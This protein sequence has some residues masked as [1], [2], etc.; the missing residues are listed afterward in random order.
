M[1]AA[2]KVSGKKITGIK[3]LKKINRKKTNQKK[4][5]SLGKMRSSLRRFDKKDFFSTGLFSAKIQDFIFEKKLQGTFLLV[6]K[7]AYVQF[8]IFFYYLCITHIPLMLSSYFA[9]LL[10][11]LYNF[12]F[13]SISTIY[14]TINTIFL[15]QPFY[16]VDNNNYYFQFFMYQLFITM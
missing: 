16:S 4:V 2:A 7:Q 1:E 8:A 14:S 5:L 10:G 6:T 3:V 15:C 12:F 9:I 11:L 13:S